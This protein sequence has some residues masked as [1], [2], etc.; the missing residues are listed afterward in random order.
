MSD[1]RATKESPGDVLTSREDLRKA[2]MQTVGRL[3]AVV[4]F[5]RDRDDLGRDELA[6]MLESDWRALSEAADRTPSMY[7]PDGRL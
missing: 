1:L 2:A 5:L 3:Q 6:E 4:G 7:W